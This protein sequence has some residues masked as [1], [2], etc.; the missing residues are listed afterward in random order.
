MRSSPTI[1]GIAQCLFTWIAQWSQ[2]KTNQAP[3]AITHWS[4]REW[5]I[6]KAVMIVHGMGPTLGYLLNQQ[7]DHPD[8]PQTINDYL[9]SQFKENK[10]RIQMITTA[11]QQIG[12]LLEQNGIR[13]VGFKGLTLANQLYPDIAMRPMA[14]ID[15]YTGQQDKDKLTQVLSQ[16][17]FQPHVITP[18]GMTL[19]QQGWSEPE[20]V[21]WQGASIAADD[22]SIWYQG[23]SCKLPFSIDVHFSMKQ[24]IQEFRYDL[25]PMFH[26]A[27]ASD[28]KLSPEQTYIHLLLH[29]S[30]H[31]RCRCARWIQLYDLF[32]LQQKLTIN[33]QEVLAQAKAG[34]FCHLLLWPLIL[35]RKIFATDPTW[36]ER[37]LHKETSW[38]YQWL[39]NRHEL[40][41]LSHCNPKDM[42]L[43]Y[44]LLWTQ[45]LTKITEWLKL[46]AK[47]NDTDFKRDNVQLQSAP[48]MAKRIINRVRRHFTPNT[49]QQWHIFALQGLAPHKDWN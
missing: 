37:Q 13:S 30:K 25:E 42:G 15:I 36:L 21:N 35:T 28:Q 16:L 32:L 18:E 5:K 17:Q 23:E 40:A 38:R 47:S 1:S 29:A 12:E 20:N 9:R 27:L 26:Q 46:S 14:D 31:F 45:N 43:F 22:D 8:L 6:A 48:P 7:C 3:E 41:T 44:S 33:E 4:D 2:G 49:R 19:Y 24:G 10:K 34:N 39:F 11:N